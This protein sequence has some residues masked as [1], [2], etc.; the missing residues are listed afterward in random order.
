MDDF[1]DAEFHIWNLVLGGTN[2]L[3]DYV[4]GYL[5]L[6]EIWH[7]CCQWVQAAN[8]IVVTFLIDFEMFFDLMD[9]VI[10]DPFLLEFT[11]KHFTFV[12]SNLSHACSS[13]SE[14]AHED[15]IQVLAE[16]LFAKHNT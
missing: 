11:S 15:W 9:V 5:F 4:L 12:N 7:D 6:L 13:V 1:A 16:R 14:I 10:D 8:S 3:W 2:E